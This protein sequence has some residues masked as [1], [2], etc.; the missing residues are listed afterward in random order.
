MITIRPE[1]H[2]DCV[3][4]ELADAYSR[5]QLHFHARAGTRDLS[6]HELR[7]IEASSTVGTVFAVDNVNSV[8]ELPCDLHGLGGNSVFTEQDYDDNSREEHNDEGKE[9]EA[10]SDV[11]SDST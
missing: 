3:Y 1:P 11:H 4:F 8:E 7:Q 9:D 2:Y 10:P 5:V 6:R